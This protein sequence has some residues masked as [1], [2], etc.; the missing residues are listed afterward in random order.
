MTTSSFYNYSNEDK[1]DFNADDTKAFA[2]LASESESEN[3]NSTGVYPNGTTF[4]NIFNTENRYQ[5]L[6]DSSGN[7]RPGSL[8]DTSGNLFAQLEG[9]VFGDDRTRFLHYYADVM[10]AKKVSRIRLGDVNSVPSTAAF[11]SLVP[12][13][14]GNDTVPYVYAVENEAGTAFVLLTCNYA[15]KGRASKVFLALDGAEGMSILT[16]PA[17]QDS[18]T[19]GNVTGCAD[20]PWA[21]PQAAVGNW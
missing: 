19:G 8:S 10:A 13:T 4:I 2:N 6:A 11:V 15:E 14:T 9:V 5:L 1:N 17:V 7:L 20:I 3:A 18:V 12:A 16:D 21:V